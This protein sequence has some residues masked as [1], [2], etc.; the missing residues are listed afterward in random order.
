MIHIK[1]PIPMFNA[2]KKKIEEEE[3]LQQAGYATA[4]GPESLLHSQSAS[5]RWREIEAQGPSMCVLSI[6]SQ[7]ASKIRGTSTE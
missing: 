7:F 6:L 5:H 1:S 2:K 3:E 4:R